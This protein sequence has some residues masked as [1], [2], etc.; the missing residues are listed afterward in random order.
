VARSRSVKRGVPAAVAACLLVACGG[1]D[2]EGSTDST[3]L[4]PEEPVSILVGT[5][6]IPDNAPLFL[7]I[8]EGYFEEEGLEVET[9]NVAGGSAALPAMVAGDLQ[10]S[11]SNWTTVLQAAGQGLPAQMVWEMSGPKEGVNGI[12]VAG[13]SPVQDPADL[14]GQRVAVNTLA[15]LVELQVRECLAAAGLQDGDYTLVE[16][17]FP[18]MP[19]AVQQGNVAGAFMGEPFVTIAEEQGQR[20]V[21]EPTVNCGE[22]VAEMPVIGFMTTS[23]YS[24]ENPEVV[25]AFARA[26]ERGAELAESDPQ[27]IVDILPTYTQLTPE[28]AGVIELPMWLEDRAPSTDRAEITME[29]MID[30]GFIDEPIEDLEAL[31]APVD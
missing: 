20:V 25:A 15:G 31:I 2:D 28:L 23:Q 21:A 1:G 12:L 9:Q 19:A 7:A 4:S 11:T 29:S 16:I 24:A 17:P 22:R 5:L 27:A 26:V 8:E 30:F 14:R 10:F 3:A 18:D 13:D 6:P